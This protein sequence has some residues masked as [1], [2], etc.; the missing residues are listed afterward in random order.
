MPRLLIALAVLLLA[1][2]VV[3]QGLTVV[4]GLSLPAGA[5]SDEGTGLFGSG[6]ARTGLAIGADIAVPLSPTISVLASASLNAN[7]LAEQTFVV[8]TDAEERL[9]TG[10]YLNVPLTVGLG[11]RLPYTARFTVEG[12]A[13][14]GFNYSQRPETVLVSPSRGD[15]LTDPA[16]SDVTTALVVGAQLVIADRWVVSPR[17]L[18][19]GSA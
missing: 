19:L 16:S 3:A 2:N 17:Y 4:G 8:G 12:F 14:G 13:Q 9:E 1:P 11:V 15:S 10:S 6:G 5:F 18:R 7:R